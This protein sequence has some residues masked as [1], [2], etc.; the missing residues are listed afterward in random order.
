MSL[1]LREKKR[2]VMQKI[3]FF[4]N[5]VKKINNHIHLKIAGI[6]IQSFIIE[7]PFFAYL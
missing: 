5:D 6:K 2:R 1:N 3:R 4:K 7:L